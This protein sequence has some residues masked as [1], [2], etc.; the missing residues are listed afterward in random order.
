MAND[1]SISHFSHPG[2][3]LVKRHYTGPFRCDMCLEGLSGLAYGC[4]AG[5][6][7]AIHDT[8]AGH[9]QVLLSPKHHPHALVL[10]QTRRNAALA[11]DVCAGGC[12]AGCFLYRCPPCGF[13][14]HPRCARLPPVVRSARHHHHDLTLV[15]ADEGRRCCTV[16]HRRVGSAG[17]A[18]YYRCTVCI[19]LEFHVSCAAT[20]GGGEEKAAG[21]GALHGHAP[22]GGAAGNGGV[23]RDVDGELV[24][25]RLK[26]QRNMNYA[27]AIA[28]I[29]AN[30]AAAVADLCG[31]YPTRRF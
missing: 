12:A 1:G 29:Q 9:K 25:A 17:G 18:W 7:F 15:V 23:P 3:E 30:G 20:G 19:N 11:C 4:R 16:C 8:C 27:I 2:H 24:L 28:N 26:A 10:L 22:A 14:M 31:D 5:C 6:D 21:G 13:D